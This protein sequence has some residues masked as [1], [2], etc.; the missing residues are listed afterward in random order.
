MK[1]I[2]TINSRKFDGLIHRSWQCELLEN[3]KNYWLFVGEFE[4]EVSHPKLGVIRRKTI[5]YEYYFKDKWFN[6]FRFHEPGGELKFYYCNINMPP[7]FENGVLDYIDLDI[8]VL[9]QKDFGFEILDEDEFIEN[10]LKFNYPPEIISRVHENLN[11]LISLINS[12]RF[13]F[14]FK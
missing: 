2:A 7:V 8:D 13:P 9:V 6:I 4:K 1:N 10:S 14:D 3:R 5:S 12:R 11:A